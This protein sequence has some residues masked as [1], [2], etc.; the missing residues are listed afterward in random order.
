L[1]NRNN[2]TENAQIEEEKQ[3]ENHD[4]SSSSDIRM[5][6]R[7]SEFISQSEIIL[8]DEEN[9]ME[10]NAFVKQDPRLIL[11]LFLEYCK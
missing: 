7:A 3:S 9:V 5:S 11:N 1:K 10:P 8:D 6:S 4:M 2:K